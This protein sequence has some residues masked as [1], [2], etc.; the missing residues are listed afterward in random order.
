MTNPISISD[1]ELDWLANSYQKLQSNKTYR[2]LS[3][4]FREFIAEY[5]DEQLLAKKKF[6]EPK[7]KNGKKKH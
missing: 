4:T 5:L 1:E 2:N 7:M 6:K 3:K